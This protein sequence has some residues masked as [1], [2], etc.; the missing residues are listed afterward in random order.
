[1]CELGARSR[2]RR[3]ISGVET[4]DRPLQAHGATRHSPRR[5]GAWAMDLDF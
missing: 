1:M 4:A 5:F 2:A 3:P